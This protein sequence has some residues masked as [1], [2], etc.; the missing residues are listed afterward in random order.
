VTNLVEAFL[1]SGA[2]AVVASLWSADD[3]Y[4]GTLMERFYIHIAEGQPKAT[5]LRHAKLD[6]LARDGGHVPPY[7]W[8]AFVMV[9]EGG[10]RFL[11][12]NDES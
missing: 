8:G 2:R 6:L 1:V 10:P 3:T 5:A 7:Y 4:T 12:G 11:W 9:G